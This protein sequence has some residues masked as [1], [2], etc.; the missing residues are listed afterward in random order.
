[1]PAGVSVSVPALAIGE[2]VTVKTPP[3][4]VRAT[5]VTVP[6][7]PLLLSVPPENVRPAPIV[8]AESVVPLLCTMPLAG[9]ASAMVPAPTMVPPVRPVPATTEVTVPPPDGVAQ[10]PSP[11]QKVLLDAPAP[12]A[13]FEVGRL[14][15]MSADRFTA[16]NDGAPAA[17]PCSTVVVVPSDPSTVGTAPVPPPRT[18]AF[19]VSAADEVIVPAAVNARTPPLVPLV[20]PVPPRGT[21]TG[22]VSEKVELVKVS[23]VPAA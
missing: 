11:R 9:A 3:G 8:A 4:L 2:P 16:P 10:V 1:M 19:C 17:L 20:R 5:L 7:P 23:P 12:P 18:M 15:V 14:P 21:V 13:R 6:V 22:E